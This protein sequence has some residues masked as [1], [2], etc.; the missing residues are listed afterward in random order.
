MK[1]VMVK[2]AG[3]ALTAVMM[4]GAGSQVMAAQTGDVEYTGNVTVEAHRAS[5]Y[6]TW[7]YVPDGDSFTPSASG[8]YFF[9]TESDR[10]YDKTIIITDANGNVVATGE[11]DGTSGAFAVVLEEGQTYNI[12]SSATEFVPNSQAHDG[13][14][15]YTLN[16]VY[17][18]QGCPSPV[19]EYTLPEGLLEDHYPTIEY[20]LGEPVYFEM[21]DASSDSTDTTAASDVITASSVITASETVTAQTASVPFLSPEQIKTMS[22]RNFVGHM[23]IECLGREC[24]NEEIGN[25]VDMLQNRGITA[26]FVAT[27]MLTS[28]EFEDLKVS[29]EEFVAILTNVFVDAVKTEDAIAALENGTT[30]VELIGQFAA[31]EQW[32]SKCAFYK[33]NV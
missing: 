3:V 9:V 7:N 27:S 13:S 1:N 28:K 26:T 23:Y 32:A 30:R 24:S 5:R 16:I 6:S 17:G 33:V 20:S 8:C 10:A 21:E 14:T 25:W 22:V 31:S 11:T 19:H 12:S 15:T 4:L 18:Y 29:N 2:A